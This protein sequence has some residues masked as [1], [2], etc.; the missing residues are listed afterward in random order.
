DMARRMNAIG[1][2][3]GVAPPFEVDPHAGSGEA[4]VADAARAHQ[5]TPAPSRVCQNPAEAASLVVGR[6]GAGVLL[7]RV[8]QHGRR[9]Q[10]ALEEGANVATHAAQ[11]SEQASMSSHTSKRRGVFVV[12]LA[13]QYTRAPRAALG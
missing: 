11:R 1:E 8:R 3:H 10:A 13:P 6:L 9:L 12:H 4:G 2:K 5:V 7:A